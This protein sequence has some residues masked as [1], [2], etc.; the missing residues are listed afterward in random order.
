MLSDSTTTIA[1]ERPLVADVVAGAQR[2]AEIAARCAEETEA[3]RRLEP[4]VVEAVREAGFGRHFVPA[5]FGGAEGSFV[6]MTAAVTVVGQGCASAAWAAS[7]SAY[8]ARYGAYLPPE[9]QAEIWADGPN[10]LMAGAL[11]PAG[12]AEPGSGG[13][14]LSGEWKYISGVRFAEWVFAC[15][16][17]P[18]GRVGPDGRPEVR[19]FAVPRA[20]ITVKDTWFTMGMRGTGSD[21]MV[22]DDVFVPECRSLSRFDINAGRA[23]ASEARCHT[24]PVDALNGLPL[25]VP[26]LGAA[27]GALRVGAEQAMRR[28][29]RRGGP[30]REKP[31]VQIELARSA[32]EVD[33]AELLMQRAARIADGLEQAREGEAAVRGPRDLALA[34]ELLVSAVDRIFKSGGT[35]V[36]FEADPLQRFWRDVST[37]ASHMIFDFE[38]TGAAFGAWALGAEGAERRR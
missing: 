25:A 34:V 24:V 6:D 30:V 2:V 18:D 29:D 35:A 28:L 21:T 12:K 26:V 36:H 38:T 15:S 11:M 10:A 33:A 31:Q 9:G 13:W 20:D 16:A 7:L 27:R 17:V 8:T 5:A 4:E 37:A 3:A 1:A 32:G 23:T 22:L 19:F 14:R